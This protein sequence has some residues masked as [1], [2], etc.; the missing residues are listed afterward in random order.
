MYSVGIFEFV[1]FAHMVGCVDKPGRFSVFCLVEAN[2]N[3]TVY[4]Q[5]HKDIIIAL[6]H[7]HACVKHMYM[8]VHVHSIV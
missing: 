4:T 8:H 3:A 2:T 7:V 6:M 5:L 1:F